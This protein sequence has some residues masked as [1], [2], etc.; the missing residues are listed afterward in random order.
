MGDAKAKRSFTG[1]QAVVH[2][3]QQQG[4]KYVFGLPG[5]AAIPLFDALV[6][7][8]IQLVLTRHEQGATH[9]ADGFARAC[10][11]PG[12]VL[13][14]S[15]PGAT[16]TITG[17]LTAKM[18]SVPMIVLTGQASVKDLG[19]D[20]FQE[21]DVTGI[22]LPVVKHSY[23]I[24]DAAD[25]P[26]VLREAFYLAS[27]GRPGPVLVD[28]PRNCSNTTIELRT[29]E[30]FHL[31]GYHVP[32][33]GDPDQVA[34]AAKL[35]HKAKRP[36][37]L[38]G[39]GAVISG[40]GEELRV[41]AETMQIPVTNTLLGKGAFPET[42]P[43]SLGMLGMHGTAYANKAVVDCDL[44]MSV[45]SRWDDRI[46]GTPD[47]FCPD[48]LKIHVDIDPAEIN[49][50]Y[51]M[52]CAIV[53]DARAVLSQL[54]RQLTPGDT[55]AWR[56]RIDGWKKAYPLAYHKRGTFE[57][58]YVIDE[59]YRLTRG[60]AIVTTDVGQHQMW[61]AQF[62]RTEERF[63]WISSGGAGTMGFG[64]PAAIGAQ[65]ARPEELVC[66][67]VGDGGF[68]MTM[69]E[70][71][72]AV[73]LK[74]PLK[75]LIINNRYLGMVRQWQNLFWENRLSGV[76]LVGNPDFVK[77]AESYGCKAFRIR[78]NRDVTPVLEKALAYSDGPV[79]IDAEVSKED[80]VFPMIPAGASMKDMI[81][82][83]TDPK[84]RA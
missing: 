40:A 20:A 41:L 63:K 50:L 47:T 66:A 38:V 49:K 79:V 15:G 18:D 26:R 43:L 56:D 37:L 24:K 12:V 53:G 39:H 65:L 62:Y 78:R 11:R 29:D 73:N 58:Q 8:P 33:E 57:A 14:T 27:S 36:V 22:S 4:V 80:N 55:Q 84:E 45:G 19:M 42:H 60:R 61:A 74:L 7:S 25:I 51:Q 72:T 31:P 81:L 34:C 77:L 16:N 76:D 54:N 5:G 59:L 52:D 75:V 9:M 6:D 69:Y 13:V 3:L 82:G 28:I 32:E 2:I 71:S 70:L 67:I 68:Q 64:F 1:A 46:T 23:L 21:A 48:A 35:L 10:G 30:D 83:P 44:V 17:I